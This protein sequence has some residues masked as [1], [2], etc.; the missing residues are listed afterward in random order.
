MLRIP[1]KAV[2]LGG[3]SSSKARETAPEKGNKRL[4]DHLQAQ[5]ILHA[6]EHT[7]AGNTN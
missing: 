6:N 3:I 1:R 2:S 7:A 5:N 4:T